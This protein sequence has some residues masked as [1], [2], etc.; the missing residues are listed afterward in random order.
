MLCG[1][2]LDQ[3]HPSS[4]CLDSLEMHD[5]GQLHVVLFVVCNLVVADVTQS[6]HIGRT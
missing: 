3:V 6:S 2:P 5:F 1:V 4:T